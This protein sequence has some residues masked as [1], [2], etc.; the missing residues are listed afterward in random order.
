MGFIDS[1]E[2]ISDSMFSVGPVFLIALSVLF[3]EDK[4]L[5]GVENLL[6]L[7]LLIL[8][9]SGLNCSNLSSS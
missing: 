6:S 5:L 9:P 4:V 8:L 1:G 3:L 2:N 7:P